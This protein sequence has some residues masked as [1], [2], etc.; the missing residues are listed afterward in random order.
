VSHF[1]LAA[2]LALLGLDEDARS[3]ARNG[4]ALNPQFTVA[5]YE[6]AWRFQDFAD[7]AGRRAILEG[8]RKAGVPER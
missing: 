7:S 6:G 5:R 1:H 8:L 4:L 3:A 2:A